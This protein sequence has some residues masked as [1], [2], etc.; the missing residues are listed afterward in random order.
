MEDPIAPVIQ[1]RPVFAHNDVEEDIS[2]AELKLAED[3]ATEDNWTKIKTLAD[4]DEQRQHSLTL[5]QAIRTY[6]AVGV[7]SNSVSRGSKLW[8]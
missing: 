5:W 7:M 3:T 4:A 1:T 6:K 8:L 2:K